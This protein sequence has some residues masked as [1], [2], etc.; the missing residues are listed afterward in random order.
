[1]LKKIDFKF[2]FGAVACFFIAFQILNGTSGIAFADP[3]NEML[4]FALV[5]VGGII[6]LAAIKK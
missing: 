5:S 4:T 3:L 6:C 2:A 1:M